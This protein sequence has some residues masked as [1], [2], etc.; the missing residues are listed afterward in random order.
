MAYSVEC[1]LEVNEVVVKVALVLYVLCN[2]DSV[3]ACGVNDHS[4]HNLVY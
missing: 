2:Y 1:L 3:I 4:V